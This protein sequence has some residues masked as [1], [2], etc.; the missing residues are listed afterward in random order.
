MNKF[1]NLI[2]VLC[3]LLASCRSEK[4][5][6]VVFNHNQLKTVPLNKEQLKTWLFKDLEQ[7]TV[8]GISLDRAYS[9]LL[10]NKKGKEIVV[11]VIDTEIETYHEDLNGF[12]WKNEDEIPNN[13]IDDDNNG[14]VDDLEGWNFIGNLTGDNIYYAN[15]ECVRILQKFQKQFN[16]IN[17][18]KDLHEND[19]LD[20]KLYIEAKKYYN[21]LRINAK[22]EL[23]RAHY[24]EKNYKK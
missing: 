16:N 11:A 13:K 19:T 10:K 15:K 18:I 14:Y 7:D 17:H 1:F 24:L 21:N 12:F 4:H 9:E 23:E 5:N 2:I 6:P 22:S 3:F 8:P 20:Y